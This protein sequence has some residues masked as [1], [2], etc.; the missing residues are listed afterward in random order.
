MERAAIDLDDGT[1]ESELWA[2]LAR[3]PRSEARE[4]LIQLHLPFARIVAAKLYAGRGRDDVEFGDYLQLATI[5]LLECVDR[6]D[7]K[8]TA[9]FRTYAGHRVTGAVLNGLR[10]MSEGREQA[11]LRKRLMQARHESLVDAELPPRDP[12]AIFESLARVAVG[13]AMGY[14]LE[15]SGMI[16]D[17]EGTTADQNYRSIEL[18]QLQRRV[19]AILENLPERERD[20]VRHHYLQQVPF[21][22][23]AAMMGVTKGRVSQL[24]RRALDMLRDETRKVPKCDIAW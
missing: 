8:R 12:T 3:D 16:R 1:E 4:R 9:T 5:G 20:I 14:L 24:H 19:R 17:E 7:A 22:T 18:R 13:L 11:S 23:I 10:S 15:D 6:Y 21:E 2:A